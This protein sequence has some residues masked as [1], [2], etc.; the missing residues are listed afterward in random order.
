[1]PVTASLDLLS[2]RVGESKKIIPKSKKMT[3]PNDVVAWVPFQTQRIDSNSISQQ[4]CWRRLE[5]C[6]QARCVRDK[7]NE[8]NTQRNR[9]LPQRALDIQSPSV[10]LA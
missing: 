10:W 9:T 1:V 5:D 6:I 7:D 2:A 4:N 8:L 3:V